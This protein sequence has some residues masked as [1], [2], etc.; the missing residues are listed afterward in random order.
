MEREVSPEC[1]KRLADT[2]E[3][4]LAA[5][6]AVAEV[7][8]KGNGFLPAPSDK[9]GAMVRQLP[10]PGS[11]IAEGSAA[12]RATTHGSMDEDTALQ[13]AVVSFIQAT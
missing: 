9:P 5:L 4:Q 2:L 13:N 7:E 3:I 12:T 10:S 6:L 8:S 11:I 1:W